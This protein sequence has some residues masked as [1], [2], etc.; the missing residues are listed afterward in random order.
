MKPLL[1]LSVLIQ[2]IVLPG[3]SQSSVWMIE[4]NGT[5]MYVGGSIHILREQDYPL[6]DEFE[7]AFEKSDILVLETDINPK[8][9]NEITSEIIGLTLYP[10]NK[11][12]K[13][14][15]RKDVYAKLDSACV[16][17][18][19]ELEKMIGFKP[20]M[21]IITLTRVELF[22]IGTNAQGVDK[23]F[24]NKTTESGKDKLFLES[25]AYQIRLITQM[26][27]SNENEYVLH[28][29]EELKYFNENFKKMIGP[30]RNGE[31]TDMLER[32]D[33]FKQNYP[34]L[35]HS[36][37]VERNNNWIVQ[38]ENYME[39]PEVEFVVVGAMHLP[40]SDGI[41]QKMKD[42]GYKV[43]QL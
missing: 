32:I 21:A 20:V 39:T 26:G 23:Y 12:L 31:T 8:D 9:K 36:I 10:N 42:K 27:E 22:K 11:S 15:L 17:S 28:S 6:P 35:Y 38:L 5:K 4:G 37:L 14:E 13:T 29:L 7:S 1:L 34:G 25:A 24:L 3:F 16:K 18:G 33:E 41:L 43:Q 30:W 2:F 40:G 19:I